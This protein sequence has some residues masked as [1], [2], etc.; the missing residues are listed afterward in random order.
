MARKILHLDLDAFFCAV[1]E[2]H[3][4]ALVGRAFAVGGRPEERGVVASCSYP[5]ASPRCSLSDADVTS[6]AR[7]SRLDNCTDAAS[8]LSHDVGAGD[9]S[10]TAPDFTRR[11][12]FN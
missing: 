1:E 12:D 6:L 8:T 2:L 9:G 5:A 7:L 10:G 11:A 3:N 4:P